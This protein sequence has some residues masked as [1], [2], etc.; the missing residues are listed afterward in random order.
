MRFLADMG[1]SPSTVAALRQAGHDAVHLRTARPDHVTALLFRVLPEIQ[2]RLSDGAVV[3]IE[4][5]GYRWR[6]MP[7]TDPDTD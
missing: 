6:P 2:N 4:A 3:T 7:F 1:V 5:A